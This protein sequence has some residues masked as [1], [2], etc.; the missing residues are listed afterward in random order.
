MASG[1][2]KGVKVVEMGGIGPAPL[3]V[4]MLSDMGAD[5]VRVDRKSGPR[6]NPMS[7]SKYELDGR[8]RRSVTIDL[9]DPRGT[10]IC[11]DLFDK[12]DVLI[13]GFRPGVMERLG[14][15]PNIVLQR[16]PRLVYGRMTGWGQDGPYARMAGHDYNYIAITGAAFATG[17]AEQPVPPLNYVG[18]YAGALVM[19]AGVLA[20]LHHA[21]RTGEGQVVDTA[22]CE[23]ASYISGVFHALRQFGNWNEE[24]WSNELDGGAPY[25]RA[26]RCADGEWISI[27]S[28]EPQFYAALLSTLG[29]P[30]DLAATQRDRSTWPALTETLTAAFAGKTQRE[31]CAIMENTDICFAPVVRFSEAPDHP[32]MKARGAFATIEGVIQPAPVP[33]FTATPS[34]IQGRAPH[35]GQHNDTA[36]VDWGLDPER[37]AGLARDGIL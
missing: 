5:V 2:L 9:K 33:R 11:L 14:L 23:A 15:G 6:T 3:A 7:G 32:Q 34:E 17:T 36:F 26:Y 30:A 27:G 16:N 1:P 24:R 8:G 13:E 18:D 20:A 35:V 12:A 29:L 4:T 25:Y 10:E 19:V 22:M 28:I 31:W 37:V 21:G